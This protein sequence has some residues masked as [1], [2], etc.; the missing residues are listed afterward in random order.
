MTEEHERIQEWLLEKELKHEFDENREIFK[1][2]FSG[3]H[4]DVRMAISVESDSVRI[5]THPANKVPAAQRAAIAEAVARANYGMKVGCFE[6]DLD[7]GELLFKVS[8]LTG[9]ERVDDRVLE[10]L[11]FVGPAM[12]ERYL[13]AFL[14]VI[15]GNEDVT[16]A[17]KAAEL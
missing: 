16:L 9:G 17:V 1:L 3:D 11:V 10:H 6:L 8:H 7:D 15:Y 12:C 5:V 14:S 4:G 2:G 13:P